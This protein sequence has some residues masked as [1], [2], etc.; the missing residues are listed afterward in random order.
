MWKD[1]EGSRT[2]SQLLGSRSCGGAD[3][4]KEH[5][6][7]RSLCCSGRESIVNAKNV[8][9]SVGGRTTSIF[10][11]AG[12]ADY[13]MRG[14]AAVALCAGGSH[15]SSTRRNHISYRD[16]HD[17]TRSNDQWPHYLLSLA[18]LHLLPRWVSAGSGGQSP[19]ERGVVVS[20]RR[21]AGGRGG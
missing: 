18:A 21:E 12:W 4:G 8:P 17:G 10:E 9:T 16:T 5:N 19:H 14:E 20:R 13:A 15:S 2:R 1:V 3:C 6:T 7:P 11:R